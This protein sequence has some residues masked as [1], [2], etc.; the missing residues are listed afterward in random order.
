VADASAVDTT[1]SD[2]AVAE[3]SDAGDAEAEKE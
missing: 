1:S 2:E 3:A